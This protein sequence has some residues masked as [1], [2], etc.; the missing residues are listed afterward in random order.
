MQLKLQ[1]RRRT[2]ETVNAFARAGTG[3]TTVENC[4]VRL[5]PSTIQ[6]LYHESLKSFLDNI[7]SDSNSSD[8]TSQKWQI[9][10]ED[11]KDVLFLPL[12]ITFHQDDETNENAPI[13]HGR[14]M[15]VSYNGGIL[16][17]GKH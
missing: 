12:K 2:S 16:Y 9:I 4:F 11:E 6:Q 5:H 8:S 3:T 7:S 17:Q 10:D 15:Y 1:L 13:C 14:T